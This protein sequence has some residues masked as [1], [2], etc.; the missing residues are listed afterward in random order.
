[1]SLKYGPASEPLGRYGTVM[2]VVE[3][4]ATSTTLVVSAPPYPVASGSLV[5]GVTVTSPLSNDDPAPGEFSYRAVVP[6]VRVPGFFIDNLLVR[7][8][9][10]IVMIRWTG[11]A[12]W[13]FEFPFPGS[14]SSTFLIR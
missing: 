11:L 7:I 8:H 9:F 5:V 6:Q 2:A 13:G 10:I 1:M 12:P 14:L 3:S 4:D